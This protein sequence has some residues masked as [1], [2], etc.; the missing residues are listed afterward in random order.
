[1]ICTRDEYID[2]NF[3]I[4]DYYSKKFLNAR[5]EYKT[6]WRKVIWF[7]T[8][9]PNTFE[10]SMEVYNHKEWYFKIHAFRDM[11][12]TLHAIGNSR[13]VDI[14]EK[15]NNIKNHLLYFITDGT[16]GKIGTEVIDG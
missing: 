11:E 3:K 12:K 9:E 5:R 7:F 1:M 14:T 16:L 6:W 8:Y 13:F 10:L 15:P 4:N 2:A